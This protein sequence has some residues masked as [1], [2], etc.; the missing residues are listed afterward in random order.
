MKALF[1][2]VDGALSQPV[3]G[4]DRLRAYL[5]DTPSEGKSGELSE[6]ELLDYAVKRLV[7][8]ATATNP[9]TKENAAWLFR[10]VLDEHHEQLDRSKLA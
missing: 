10:T 5:R 3:A 8:A 2:L 1:E 7:R 9:T 6:N 4:G